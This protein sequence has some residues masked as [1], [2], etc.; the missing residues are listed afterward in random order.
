MGIFF[1][2]LP[3]QLS[4]PG[5]KPLAPSPKTKTKGPWADTTPPPTCTCDL[6]VIQLLRKVDQDL[7]YTTIGVKG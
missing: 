6:I 4:S 5:P 7:V 2:M 3:T 1:G